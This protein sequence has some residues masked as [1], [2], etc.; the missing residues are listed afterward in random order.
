MPARHV[1]DKRVCELRV[2]PCVSAPKEEEWEPMQVGGEERS[3]AGCRLQGGGVG[4]WA[5]IWKRGSWA[6]PF[7][8]VCDLAWN[9]ANKQQLNEN[10]VVVSLFTTVLWVVPLRPL[11]RALAG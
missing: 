10:A 11:Q 1:W 3:R 7:A 9:G 2:E 4:G 8:H 5:G 6:E